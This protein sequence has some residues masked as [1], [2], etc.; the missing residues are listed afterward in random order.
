MVVLLSSFAQALHRTRI[1]E[2][3]QQKELVRIVWLLS[4]LEGSAKVIGVARRRLVG[5]S[6]YV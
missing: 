6:K 1:K 5:G 4:L 3:M 2:A